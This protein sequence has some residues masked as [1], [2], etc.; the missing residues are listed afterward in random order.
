MKTPTSFAVRDVALLIAIMATALL[1]GS[2]V[3]QPAPVGI[4]HFQCY[5]IH[6]GRRRFDATLEDQFGLSTV[7]VRRPK[8]ICNPAD[9]NGEDPT[10]PDARDHLVGYRIKQTTPKFKRIRGVQITNQFHPTEPLVVNVIRPDFMMVPSLKSQSQP[11]T[12][13]PFLLDHFKCYRVKGARFRRAGVTIKDQFGTIVVDIKRPRRL[14]V[15]AEKN[16][17]GGPINPVDHLMCYEVRL[18][19]S[20]PP[21]MSAGQI[22]INNQF[23]PDMFDAFRPTELCVPSSKSLGNGSCS[24]QRG[25]A[26]PVCGGSCPSPNDRCLFT[27][28]PDLG[29]P[30]MGGPDLG[31]PEGPTCSCHPV[32][33]A[34]GQ[35]FTTGVCGGLCPNAAEACLAFSGPDMGGPDMGGPD[36]GGPDMGG[37]DMSGPE[38]CACRPV[39]EACAFS[40]TAAMCG[41]L[42]PGPHQLCLSLSGPD[43]GGPDI[44]GPE[45]GCAC[46]P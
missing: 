46:T 41:G 11:P 36:M 30:D 27:N 16:N 18:A 5:E 2:A 21:F 24:V 37:P 23:G 43:L 39:F 10:A 1:P 9:K 19:A 20:S 13:T 17:E 6:A 15:P 32:T 29:G 44:S 40:A 28:G 3:A 14:C 22:F 12:P 4:N 42:C 25:A 7:H 31:G 8:R 34:C 35:E 26:A 45:A 38:A 33:E